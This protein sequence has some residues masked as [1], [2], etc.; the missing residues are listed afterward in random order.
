MTSAGGE[1][2]DLGSLEPKYVKF[3]KPQHR[4]QPAAP[5]VAFGLLLVSFSLLAFWPLRKQVE[6]AGDGNGGAGEDDGLLSAGE[7][8]LWRTVPERAAVDAFV[9]A[10]LER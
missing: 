9:A 4:W 3:E 2:V 10:V 8:G 7:D 5:Y 1:Y 6:P